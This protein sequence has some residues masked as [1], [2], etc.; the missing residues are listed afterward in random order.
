M[1]LDPYFSVVISRGLECESV[2]TT[3]KPTTALWAVLALA[4]VAPE[5]SIALY[6]DSRVALRVQD[7]RWRVPVT[8][9]LRRTA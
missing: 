4:A 8:D 5:L 9:A 1:M 6:V 2:L 7:G 3:T